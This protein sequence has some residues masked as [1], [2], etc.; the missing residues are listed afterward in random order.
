MKS[1]FTAFLIAVS[2]SFA[3]AQE[4][5]QTVT[6]RGN[7]T[8][9]KIVVSSTAQ[10]GSRITAYG[11]NQGYFDIYNN[12]NNSMSLGLKRSDGVSVFEMDGHTMNTYFGGNVGIGTQSPSTKLN[13]ELGAGSADGTVGLKIGSI[14]NYPSL[15]LGVEN[16]YDAQIRTYGN[17][18]NIY[19]G[20]FR[21]VGNVSSEN[22]KINFYTS[23][24]GSTNWNIPKMI[25]TSDGD[26]GI[27]TTTPKEKLS[28]NGKIRA[29]EVKV[30]TA[31]WPDYVFEEG[32]E[33][34]TLEELESYIKLNKHLP[35]FPSAKEVTTNGVE[36]GDM[37]K[38]LLKTQEKLTLQ[39]IE[40]NKQIKLLNQK[41]ENI[42]SKKTK[43][44]K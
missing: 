26:V 16:N 8:N 28:V 24:S 41:L 14:S 11:Y 22:H 20:H 4:T 13:I 17:D 32:Y 44:N 30:E 21:T 34:G 3:I 29:H 33:I 10:F 40:Q 42:S 43:S 37:V 18:L 7:S 19:A 27:G 25:L 15:E 36:L 5:L 2:A 35:D 38:Q 1:I 12:S 39:L 9:N 23:K 6:D 31:N